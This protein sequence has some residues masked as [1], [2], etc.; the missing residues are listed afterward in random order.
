MVAIF[1]VLTIITC[2]LVDFIVQRVQMKKAVAS[3]S[4]GSRPEVEG[5]L[6]PSYALTG[7]ESDSFLVPKG[8]FFHRGH[9]W[10]G[11]H[12]SG[13]VRVGVDDFTQNIL[14]SF[15]TIKTRGVGEEVKQ[16]E[17]LF[18]IKQGERVATFVSPVDGVIAAVNEDVQSNPDAIKQEPYEKGWIYII[19]PTNLADNI[20]N[21][22]ISER[23]LSWLQKEIE[24]FRDFV[25]VQLPHNALVG[26]TLQDGGLPVGG[27]LEQMDA[28][29]WNRFEAQFLRSEE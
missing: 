28:E 26:Q 5:A 12:R 7:L 23:A 22:N 18:A 25:K 11:L 15:D 9:T 14:G 2:L 3:V 16:G 20:R 21:L 6:T 4:Q 24:S 10:A 17:N 19:N 8:V 27:L 29:A 1:V 13:E